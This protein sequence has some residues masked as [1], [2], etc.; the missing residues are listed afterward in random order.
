MIRLLREAASQSIHTEYANKLL[1]A[2]QMPKQRRTEEESSPA[3]PPSDAPIL[4]DPL[5]PRELD[6]LHLINQGLSNND[7]AA[8]LVIALN[9]VKRHTSSIYGKLGVRSRTQ[10]IA[11]AR[12]LGLIPPSALS[13]HQ[14]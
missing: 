2:F 10:A 8:E 12:E 3:P 13:C 6:V 4:V 14:E 7:I 1:A 5:T 11:C 9:T